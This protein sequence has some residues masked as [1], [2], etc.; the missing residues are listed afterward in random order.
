MALCATGMPPGK[1][2]QEKRLKQWHEEQRR[3][4]MAMA[5]PQAA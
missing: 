5:R 2:K 4:S 1:G 3:L